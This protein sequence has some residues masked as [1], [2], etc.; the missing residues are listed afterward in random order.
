MRTTGQ[1]S[2]DDCRFHQ[3]SG[4]A[5][6]HTRRR[7]VNLALYLRV[8]RNGGRPGCSVSRIGF[9]GAKHHELV[10]G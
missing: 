7:Y 1:R 6:T 5:R 8:R 9:V 10:G 3:S 2:A 4:P